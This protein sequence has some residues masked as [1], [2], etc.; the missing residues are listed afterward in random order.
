MPYHSVEFRQAAFEDA[1]NY[2]K[3]ASGG[4]NLKNPIDATIKKFAVLWMMCHRNGNEEY[5]V[6]P[7]WVGY[8]LSKDGFHGVDLLKLNNLYY[9]FIDEEADAEDPC[10]LD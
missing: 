3:S 5:I 6:V 10:A 7:P 1:I 8:A 9:D 2:I 4:M